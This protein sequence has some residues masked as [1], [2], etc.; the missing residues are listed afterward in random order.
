MQMRRRY[1]VND[2]ENLLFFIG[3]LVSV[4]G[5]DNLVKAMPSVLKE[6]PNTKL[7][8]LGVGDMENNI[9]LL[10]ENYGLQGKVMLRAE[11]VNEKE[12]IL[13]YAAS[14][15]V[16]LPSLYEPFGIVCT[17]G[18]SMAKPV[19]VGARGTNGMREQIISSGEK[20]CGIHIDPYSPE[21]IAW[22]IIQVLKSKDKAIQMGK[23]AR[24]RAIEVFSLD[25]VTNRLIGIYKEFI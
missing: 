9:R 14:D 13:H 5:V 19:V 1:G 10:I 25:A 22:G 11:F 21:D 3:R 2:N 18:M 17:E 8:I 6:F 16:V 23:N 4:K 20:Q 12:R 24:E 15:V 7:V